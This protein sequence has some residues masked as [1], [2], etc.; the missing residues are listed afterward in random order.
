MSAPPTGTPESSAPRGDE[1]PASRA[2]RAFR[3]EWMRLDASLTPVIGGKGMRA[4]FSRT[5]H[6]AAADFPWLA[7]LPPGAIAT[8]DLDPLVAA[9]E[10][11]DA[12][13]ADT[14][15]KALLARFREVL[16][17]LVGAALTDR[18][19]GPAQEPLT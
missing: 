2:A 18:L 19:I 10:G 12:D 6:L 16:A 9:M 4:L 17:S 5:L 11:R 8:M 3:A 15:S 7:E 14:V 1:A 13:E